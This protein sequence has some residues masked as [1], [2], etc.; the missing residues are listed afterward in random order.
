MVFYQLWLYH[1]QILLKIVI[2]LED[3]YK[4]EPVAKYTNVIE[5]LRS[6]LLADFFNVVL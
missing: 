6:F 5:K 3:A 1:S 2:S 4:R